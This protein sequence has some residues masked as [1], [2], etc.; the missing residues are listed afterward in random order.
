MS[1]QISV[2]IRLKVRD[3]EM[4]MLV[5]GANVSMKAPPMLLTASRGSLAAHFLEVQSC[6]V[7]ERERIVADVNVLVQRLGIRCPPSG[8][9]DM[10]LPML[11][12]KYL[13]PKLSRPDSLSRS[14]PVILY[15]WDTKR[16]V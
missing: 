8:S 14:L 10:N 3:L 7:G 4:M 11:D 2:L 16:R 5:V 13:A 15:A 12:V 1:R 9:G 6:W